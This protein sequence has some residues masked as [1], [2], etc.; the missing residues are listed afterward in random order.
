MASCATINVNAADT[1]VTDINQLTQTTMKEKFQEFSVHDYMDMYPR[2]EVRVMTKE[3]AI[4]FAD[5]INKNYSGGTTKYVGEMNYAQA[6]EHTVRMVRQ[7]LTNTRDDSLDF[8]T[9]VCEKFI[10]CYTK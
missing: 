7:E 10:N 4:E 8:I 1:H 6:F 2:Q 5:H 9:N 3:Q